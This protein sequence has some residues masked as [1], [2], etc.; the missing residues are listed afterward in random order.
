MEM[1]ERKILC[2]LKTQFHFSKNKVASVLVFIKEA[3]KKMGL[4]GRSYVTKKSSKIYPEFIILT[5]RVE[6]YILVTKSV[7][8]VLQM[9]EY[10]ITVWLHNL[11]C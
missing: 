11:V 6:K 7:T 2:L 5:Y 8:I 1:I 9:I 10:F 3:K 4:Q